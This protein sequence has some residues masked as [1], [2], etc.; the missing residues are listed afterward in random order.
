MGFVVKRFGN[1]TSVI[2]FDHERSLVSKQV[3]KF[4]KYSVFER[5]VYWLTYLNKKGYPW[6]PRLVDHNPHTK[7][8]IMEY[9]G[10]TITRDNKPH[11]WEEQLQTILHDLRQERIQHN[12]IKRQELL[13]HNGRVMLIDYGWA[14][15]GKDYS[16]CQGFDPRIKPPPPFPDSTVFERIRLS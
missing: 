14:S 5:E 13:V 8:M 1:A 16:C 6:C 3:I 11:D 10:E 2:A 7:T 4:L 9:A 12:D 15:L